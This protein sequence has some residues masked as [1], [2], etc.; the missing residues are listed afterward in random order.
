MSLIK[1]ELNWYFLKILSLKRTLIT[2]NDQTPKNKNK[3][4]K[5]HYG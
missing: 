1:V 2:A 5:S 3:C 4:I